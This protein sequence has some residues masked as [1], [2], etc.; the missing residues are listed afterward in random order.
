MARP[1]IQH[2]ANALR[3]QRGRSSGMLRSSPG[4]LGEQQVSAV[5]AGTAAIELALQPLPVQL[6]GTCGGEGRAGEKADRADHAG[7]IEAGQARR[8]YSCGQRARQ[9]EQQADQAV[10]DSGSDAHVATPLGCGEPGGYPL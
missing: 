7:D 9:A 10:E 5:L 1:A 3:G 2:S 8:Q 6:A 4:G